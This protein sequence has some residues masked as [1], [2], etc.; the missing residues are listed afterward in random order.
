MAERRMF[1]KTITNSDAFLDMPMSAQCLYFHLS[2]NADDEGFI[3]SPKKIMR[4]IN[5]HDDDYKLL[6]LKRFII[7]FDT[8]V[9]VIKHWRINN[10]LQKD[11]CKETIFQEEKSMLGIKTNKAYTLNFSDPSTKL[12]S[13]KPQNVSSLDTKCIQKPPILDTECIH[14]VYSSDTECIHD[15]YKLDTTCI[16]DQNG[17][18][19]ENRMNTESEKDC[20]Q[21][22]QDV[23][24]SYTQDRLDKINNLIINLIQSNRLDSQL[25]VQEFL[26]GIRCKWNTLKEFSVPAMNILGP[27]TE[28]AEAL[29]DCLTKY[30]Y[31]S[32]D[33]CI[34]NIKK[35]DYLLGRTD[36]RKYPIDFK[37]LI[38]GDNYGRVY[39]GQYNTYAQSARQNSRVRNFAAIENRK[40]D[41]N[42]LEAMLLDN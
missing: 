4:M 8:G 27:N 13:E 14:D 28:R 36:A 16:H 6:V 31:D 17:Q 33:V 12:L 40:E 1:A 2:M 38:T 21:C 20:K 24:S 23:Y 29:T 11:R 10:Y 39:E 19:S 22:I 37:W 18:N 5:A 35:S 15:V 34:D 9:V 42:E 7:T 32:F 25:S 3:N 26:E 30:G 41:F